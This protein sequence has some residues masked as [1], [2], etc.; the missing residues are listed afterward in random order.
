MKE[1]K[2]FEIER[3]FL[4]KMP[5]EAELLSLDGA[6]CDEMIQT[7]LLCDGGLTH[8]VRRRTHGGV[9]AYTE[10]KKR[11]LSDLT[12][13]EEEREIGKEEYEALLR[14]ADP[15]L[16]PIE[17]KRYCIPYGGRLLEVDIYPFWKKSAIL[18]IELPS[19]EAPFSLPPHLYVLC[20]VS[21]DLA[22]KNLSLAKSVP[23]E[24]SGL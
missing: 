20:E 7:Y 12:C 19:E 21:G 23:E 9:T 2:D 4:I 3:K 14:L 1:K 15:S 24:P 11:R 6:F 16:S 13:I 22:Y 10:T 18:E 5:C 8:R 17:K